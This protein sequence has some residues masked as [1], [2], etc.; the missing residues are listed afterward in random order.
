MYEHVPR[1]DYTLDLVASAQATRFYRAA[2]RKTLGRN[3]FADPTSE[4]DGEIADPSKLYD[5]SAKLSTMLIS[6]TAVIPVAAAALNGPYSIFA[7]AIYI[8]LSGN[9]ATPRG[10]LA[11][12]ASVDSKTFAGLLGA[13]YSVVADERGYLDIVG[14]VR[15]W[16]AETTITLS[17]GVLDGREES[18]GAT[19]IDAMAGLRGVYELTPNVFLTA[20]GLIGAGQ[21][22]LDWDVS[23]SIGYKFNDRISSTIGYRALGV[24]Y[25]NGD[26]FKFDVVEHGPMVG[27]SVKF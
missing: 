19:W 2:E 16:S 24:D 21:A 17:G 5:A 23:A 3:I 25:D 9:V 6:R 1:S 12:E 26:G 22:D 13:G 15:V 4:P 8:D 18:D 27:L 7:D 14:G 20:W 11:D 10:I